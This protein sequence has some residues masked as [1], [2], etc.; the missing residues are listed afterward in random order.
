MGPWEDEDSV[1][2]DPNAL[3]FEKYRLIRKLG[4]GGMG[5]VW[6]VE[7]IDLEQQRALKVMKSEVADNETNRLRFRQEAKILAKLSRH[8]NAVPVHDTGFAGKFAY[9][10]MEYIEGQTLRKR[11]E[12]T[13]RT[14]LGD[15]VW[16]LG[17][18][19]AVM[20]EA[21]RLGIIHRDIKPQNIMVVPDP[22]AARGE[23][24][25]V[26]DF[27]IAK[28]IRDAAAETAASLTQEHMGPLGTI[29]Y[30][31]PEQLGLP[32]T[33]Q[34]QAVVDHRSDIYSLGVLLYEML[35]GVRPFTGTHTKILYDHAHTPPP[36]FAEL[37]PAVGVP[38]AV[39][40]VVRRCLEKDPAD[41]HQ[42]VRE[43][44]ESFRAAV[45]AAPRLVEPSREREEPE[46]EEPER[47]E[48]RQPHPW[49]ERI[50]TFLSSQKRTILSGLAAAAVFL[51]VLG[52]R[53]LHVR[54]TPPP[55]PIL[56]WL[57]KHGY[58]PDPSGGL[59]EG[60]WPQRI[61]EISGP[62]RRQMVLH[63][64][65]YLPDRFTEDSPSGTS[66]KTGLPKVLTREGTRFILLEGGD[67]RMGD[68]N[69][70]RPEGAEPIH[71]YTDETP[72]HSMT[73]SSFYM[74]ETEVSI[75]EFDR[76]CRD[77]YPTNTDPD[78]SPFYKAW[79][80]LA[81]NAHAIL[82][83]QRSLPATGVS[84]K[85]AREYARWL[86]LRADLPS[87]AQWE[88][89]ARSRGKPWLYV[90]GNDPERLKSV[91]GTAN[92]G[93][94]QEKPFPVGPSKKNQDR[95]EQGIYDLAGNVRE[96][97]RD[98]W[99]TYSS[100]PQKKDFVR[101]PAKRAEPPAYVI[102]GGSYATL[103]ETAR[104]TWRGRASGNAVYAMKDD[105][106]EEDLGFRVVLEPLELP[107][108]LGAKPQT[109]A[110]RETRR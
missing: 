65:Y 3:L 104:T 91:G 12:E 108:D 81:D 93:W 70:A 78:V 82:E 92:V 25:K 89:A 107:A 69:T 83:S 9:I 71:F 8:P 53:T 62:P 66:E 43:L 38:P 30:S 40:A 97:C 2:G 17:E 110:W 64:R 88:F 48:Q 72:G 59:G 14:P 45:G 44:F 28:I 54:F 86:G 63:G 61:Q 51:G 80:D 47:E 73:L 56:A 95:T 33:G 18:I 55:Q 5:S 60:D 34:T 36:P 96:W 27:G 76:F 21:H 84:R 7:H 67:F 6:L 90:W 52:A 50:K 99:G 4:D 77:T 35:T 26:L 75:D 68:F 58:E 16:I 42:S 23:R 29:P 94:L 109:T 74:Q 24:V 87:E 100:D 13:G 46:R 41:R 37:A 105:G 22:S 85:M 103:T 49:R 20:G 101:E 106:H 98:A 57:E 31:S 102:R 15:A 39:E 10:E 32:Q 1:S 79:Q 11:L 19:C